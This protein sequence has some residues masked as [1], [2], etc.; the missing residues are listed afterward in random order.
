MNQL[1]VRRASCMSLSR[2]MSTSPRDLRRELRD[3]NHPIT[4]KDRELFA[5]STQVWARVQS[6]M[7][8]LMEIRIEQDAVNKKRNP[9]APESEAEYKVLQSVQHY[10]TIVAAGLSVLYLLMSD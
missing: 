10:T 7:V 4:V 1:V 2:M 6:D 5:E 3:P 8:R 9:I